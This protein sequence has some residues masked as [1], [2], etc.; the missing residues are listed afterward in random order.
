MS[1][2]PP[3]CCLLLRKEPSFPIATSTPR[4]MLQGRGVNISPQ[5]AIAWALTWVGDRPAISAV[6]VQ[7]CG[8]T[9]ASDSGSAMK[10]CGGGWEA[11]GKRAARD[12]HVASGGCI[13]R[14]EKA[15]FLQRRALLAWQLATCMWPGKCIA[16]AKAGRGRPLSSAGYSAG[17]RHGAAGLSPRAAQTQPRGLG[18]PLSRRGRPSQKGRRA[19][20]QTG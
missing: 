9:A 4:L 16:E 14:V 2:L 19:A 18:A 13:S 6:G 1:A 15:V 17:R 12:C 7:W 11:A 10:E 20:Q 8:S 5:K 3:T